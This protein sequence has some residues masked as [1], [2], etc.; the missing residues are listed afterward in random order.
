MSRT[1]GSNE[2]WSASG[3][4]LCKSLLLADSNRTRWAIPLEPTRFVDHQ[5]LRI[6]ASVDEHSATRQNRGHSLDHT[7]EGIQ[8]GTAFHDRAVNID[9]RRI[10]R[11][12]TEPNQPA[13]TGFREHGNHQ[14]I[15]RVMERRD[16]QQAQGAILGKAMTSLAQGAT[17]LV[18]VLVAL[19]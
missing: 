1:Y 17:G 9:V 3:G 11:S 6:C 7:V 2:V 19:Q 16:L 5:S 15:D 10:A 8:L 12:R 14:V 18:L 13:R 4:S